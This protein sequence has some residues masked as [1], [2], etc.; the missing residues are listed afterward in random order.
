MRKRIRPIVEPSL[1]GSGDAEDMPAILVDARERRRFLRKSRKRPSRAR[2]VSWV[3]SLVISIAVATINA[4]QQPGW[5]DGFFDQM[6]GKLSSSATVDTNSPRA[7]AAPNVSVSV[8]RAESQR[9]NA[10]GQSQLQAPVSAATNVYRCVDGSRQSIFSDRP[11]GNVT[12]VRRYESAEIN[13]YSPP[14]TAP[15]SRPSRGNG[16]GVAASR[17]A[18]S[19]DDSLRAFQSEIRAG[20]CEQI[21]D[22]IDAVNARMRRGY[23]SQ[24]GERLRATL[25]GLKKQRDETGCR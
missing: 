2:G 24:E 9:T 1:G 3:I 18:P 12:E 14:L 20:Q 16:S 22:S 19:S 15:A 10:A 25:R 8:P 23:T 6:R 13:T 11:C 17:S 5:L 4:R 7:A 21:Q